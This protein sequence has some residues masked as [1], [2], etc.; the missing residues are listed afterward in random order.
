MPHKRAMVPLV[1]ELE[2]EARISGAN[3]RVIQ[4]PGCAVS[5]RTEAGW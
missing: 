3:T 4:P 2:E 5:T 1:D